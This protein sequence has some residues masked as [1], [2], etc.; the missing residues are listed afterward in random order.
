M[1]TNKIIAEYTHLGEL[2]AKEAELGVQL[3][4]LTKEQR[5]AHQEVIAQKDKIANMENDREVKVN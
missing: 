3:I 1:E 2:V 4:L 5:K